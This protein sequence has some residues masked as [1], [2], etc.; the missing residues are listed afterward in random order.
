LPTGGVFAQ[1]LGIVGVFQQPAPPGDET[2][3]QQDRRDP[4]HAKRSLTGSG[5]GVKQKGASRITAEIVLYGT[6][7]PPR[8]F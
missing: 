2:D 6:N 7:V 5:N 1:M 8:R 3:Q 4:A